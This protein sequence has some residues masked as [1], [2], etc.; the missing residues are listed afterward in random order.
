MFLLKLRA[1]KS[2]HGRKAAAVIFWELRLLSGTAGAVLSA[3]AVLSLF[4]IGPFLP[5]PPVLR[6]AVF[7]LSAFFCL[8]F[9]KTAKAGLWIYL[10]S[11]SPDRAVTD[12]L[13][14]KT[15]LRFLLADSLAF[16]RRIIEAAPLF[17]PPGITCLTL[18]LL[19]D[20]VG[21]P[22]TVFWAGLLT[23]AL[24]G[25]LSLTAALFLRERYAAADYLLLLYPLMSPKQALRRSRQLTESRLPFLLSVD[26]VL[27]PWR[28][29]GLLLLPLPFSLTYAGLTRLY[30]VKKIF[31]KS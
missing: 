15:G 29:A 22:E 10:L 18:F 31:E 25:L 7:C 28:L 20:S 30:A 23:G 9:A 2:S 26:V 19:T 16:L 21:L 17:L 24:Q 13:R 6:T 8:V 3:Y 11:P 27:L 12:C 5:G 1:R 4:G 14:L